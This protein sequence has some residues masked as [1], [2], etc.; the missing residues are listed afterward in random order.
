MTAFT[1]SFA[2]L[3]LA[4]FI[5]SEGGIIGAELAT[6]VIGGLISSTFLTLI[7]VPVV[8]TLLHVSVPGLLHGWGSRLRGTQP[9]HAAGARE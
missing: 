9:A 8:Y 3:P 1:T 2:L 7:V 5:T 6:V 4:T